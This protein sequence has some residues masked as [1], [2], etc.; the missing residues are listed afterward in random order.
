MAVET[1]RLALP[2]DRTDNSPTT[3]FSTFKLEIYNNAHISYGLPFHQA[4]AKH[5][6]S[7]FGASRAYILVSKTLANTSN[8]LQDLKDALGDKVAGVKMG[9]KAHTSWSDVL[10]M[11]HEFVELKA[12]IIVTLGGGSLTDAAKLLSL[13]LA[14]DVNTPEDFHT[15]LRS[16]GSKAPADLVVAPPKVPV[17]CVPTTLSGGEYS[18][19]AGATEDATDK[20]FQFLTGHAIRLL[21]LDGDLCAR[22]TP[23]RL[24]IASGFR[25][26]DHCVESYVSMQANTASEDHATRGL[27]LLIPALLKAQA[28]AENK[29]IDARIQGQLGTL[30]AMAALFRVYTPAGASHAIGHML[31]PFGVSHGET[32]AVL[33]PAVCTYNAKHDANTQ[34]QE[35]L[36]KLLW[37]LPE[38]K[39]VG[40]R[41]G[42]QE[43][44]AGLGEMLRELTR[45]LGL[46]TT[47]KEVGVEGARVEKLAEYSLLDPWIK[48]NPSPLESKEQVLEVLQPIIG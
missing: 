18:M 43:G 19:A 12:D 29:E 21:V 22:T 14:N 42:L 25:A 2:A 15:K 20:K 24:W 31:G 35:A 39:V 4:V 44:E 48:T 9:L 10:D 17:I 1:Y 7:T 34:R 33:L 5:V 41:R 16:S 23:I 6:E 45:E 11:K 38:F 40:E 30:E 26:I 32:S 8:A 28:D 37:E 36:A 46:P 27:K 47:L 13:V 3:K